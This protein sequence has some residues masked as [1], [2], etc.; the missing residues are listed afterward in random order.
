M[1]NQFKTNVYHLAQQKGSLLRSLVRNESQHAEKAY[2]DYLGSV[3]AKKKTGRHVKVEYTDTP[4][5]RRMVSLDD[6]YHADMVDKEDKIKIIQNPESEYSKAFYMAMGRQID[7]I[8]IDQLIGTA[9][10]GKTGSTAV[11]M[12]ASQRYACTTG[13]AFGNL[14]VA[15]LR[16]I[17]KQFKQNE[18]GDE[19]ICL[20]YSAE[21]EDSLLQETE[22]TSSDY[23]AVK[24]LV[25]GEINTFMGIKFVSIER[26][27]ALAADITV[28]N[29]ATG[30]VS[31]GSDTI[32]AAT[33]KRCI[34]FQK[35]GFV[36]A[37]GADVTAKVD[38]LPE[39]HY[40][41]QVYFSMTMGGARMEEVR[42]FEVIAT[43]PS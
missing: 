40:A 34:A 11:T 29:V 25:N 10:S 16:K 20:V 32:A 43:E 19:P 18:C 38:P 6:Y 36:L 2:Y 37:V 33:S 5:S 21:Q 31:G 12:P 3:D 4:H 1:V 23:A 7:D 39:Y 17:R 14:K 24:A 22:V 8:I 15:D 13:S 28:G 42:V 35:S 27:D 9:Y 41:N 30:A 26:L